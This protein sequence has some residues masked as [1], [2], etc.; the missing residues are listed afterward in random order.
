MSEFKIE[1]GITFPATTQSNATKYPWAA[2]KVG[3]SFFVPDPP[4][5]FCSMCTHASRFLEI[6]LATRKEGTG[7][8]VWRIA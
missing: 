2:L 5:Y 7:R 4:K 1:T 3:D 8:R 6:R